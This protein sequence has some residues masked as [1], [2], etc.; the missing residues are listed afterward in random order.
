MSVLTCLMP[1]A[2]VWGS[3]VRQWLDELLPAN[4]ADMCRS[5]FNPSLSLHTL[6]IKFGAPAEKPEHYFLQHEGMN[7]IFFA[8]HCL[9]KYTSF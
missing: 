5:D 8:L 9:Q 7:N 4:A 3:I 2:G 6:G 1:C